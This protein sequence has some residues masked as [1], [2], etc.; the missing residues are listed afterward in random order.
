MHLGMA[1]AKLA[2][3]QDISE[4]IQKQISTY[5]ECSAAKTEQPGA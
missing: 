4:N 5:S 1:S 2:G 3:Y